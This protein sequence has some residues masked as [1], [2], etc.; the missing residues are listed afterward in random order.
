MVEKKFG[1]DHEKYGFALA[2]V[3]RLLAAQ[4]RLLEA[5]EYMK[6]ADENGAKVLPPDH[7]EQANGLSMLAD[8]YMQMGRAEEAEP[9]FKKA[10]EIYE[11]WPESGPA[12]VSSGLSNL[13][14]DYGLIGRDAE[15]VPLLERALAIREQS[16]S[17]DD[18]MIALSMTNLAMSYGRLK[19]SDE[20]E[21]M[22][23]RALAIHEGTMPEGAR[24]VVNALS[25]LA[26][27]YDFSDRSKEAEPLFR[28]AVA[29][30][31]SLYPAGHPDL[32]RT[33]NNLASNLAH[34]GKYDEAVSIL[35]PILSSPAAV[36][37]RGFLY[38]TS[39]D[40]LAGIAFVQKDWPRA[41]DYE[42]QATAPLIAQATLRDSASRNGQIN[43]I[44]GLFRQHVLMT[45]RA[46]GD[47]QALINEG[48]E[49]GQWSARSEAAAS[50]A[51]MSAR[52]A[53]G[54]GA[55]VDVVRQRQD[56]D[57][58]LQISDQRLS[59]AL[60][61]G[62]KEAA[63]ASRSEAAKLGAQLVALNDRLTAEFP[64]YAALANPRP[65]SVSEVQ[66]LLQPD[67]ALILV[68]ELLG[69][70][71]IPS[72][73]YVWVITKGATRRVVASMAPQAIA[74][75]VRTL[76]CGLDYEGAWAAKATRCP[77]LT[78]V[79]YTESDKVAGK[80]LPF[81]LARAH[82]LYKALF[83]EVEGLIKG[84]HLLVVPSAALSQLPFQVLVTSSPDTTATGADAFRRAQWL[85]RDHAITVLPAVSSIKALRRDARDSRATKPLLGIGNPLLDGSGPD[86][87]V[88]AKEARSK[89][90]CPSPT[91]W[92]KAAGVF[93]NLRGGTPL[94]LRSGVASVE[95]LRAAPPLPETADELCA[96]ARSVN[97]NDAD[98]YLGAR[99]TE[100]EI[101]RL[102][103]SGGLAKYRYIHFATHGAL[104]GQVRGSPEPGL[105]LTPPDTATEA[106]DGYLSASEIS[107][108]KLDADWVIL[109]A[110]NTAAGEAEDAESLSGL[111]RAF[112]FAGA[113]ALLVSHWSVNSGA[114]VKLITGAI[115]RMTADK[116][117]GR[118]EALR[119]AMLSLIYAGA[120]YDA[121]PATWAPFVVVGEGA[122]TK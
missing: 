12:E 39:R 44:E 11:K 7:I 68:F 107:E 98:L 102:S 4:G 64:S 61:S 21:A 2:W 73:S 16:L 42:R 92:Q 17:A 30:G 1:A 89:Q 114:T 37:E 34:I 112:F 86:Q 66:S 29:L 51:Q 63:D 99:A 106:D 83:G 36:N 28:Q 53:K 48:F 50:L 104:S 59:A 95:Q 57:R 13:G 79:T 40:I 118:A 113:R 75:N 9:M 54:Q 93:A 33:I 31:K 18:Q 15:A 116:S 97:A 119:Q 27:F 94:A 85:I 10:L 88:R 122:V 72:E 24:N 19:R 78:K 82:E 108:L 62:D 14:V 67:E 32:L 120:D 77:E 84:K 87:A 55:L 8:L 81:D 96:V 45:T 90:S 26:S 70:S 109:S 41:L 38:S 80:P 100:T 49:M 5:E 56:I 69:K 91:F 103:E 111:A 121:H 43:F 110:C 65:L 25:N 35:L 71:I 76:R 20:A 74:E 105:V 117:I 46:G 3:G 52:F 47:D 6:R 58:Q 22:F 115:S 23:K 60:G 101:K